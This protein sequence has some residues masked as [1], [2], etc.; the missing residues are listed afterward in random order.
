MEQYVTRPVRRRLRLP[1][2]V[3]AGLGLF[4]FV[5]L[6]LSAAG[7]Q[8]VSSQSSQ[9]SQGQQAPQLSGQVYQRPAPGPT[10]SVSG[11]AVFGDTQQPARFSS[12][13]LIP[14]ESVQTDPSRPGGFRGFGGMGGNGRTDL[15]GTFV[16]NNVAVGDYYVAG[17]SPG[18]I[19]ET[20]VLQARAADGADMQ[21]LLASLPVARVTVGTTAT[22]NL[23]LTRG[24]TIAGRIQWED[25]SPATGQQVAAMMV[26]AGTN[27][28]AAINQS[29][30][31]TLLI[32]GAFNAMSDDRGMFRLTGLAPGTYVVRASL[33]APA[34]GSGPTFFQ[35]TQ[36]LTVYAPGKLRR[37]DA[38]SIT[39]HLGEERDD[40]QWVIDLHA[41]HN[42]SGRV[43]ATS[44]P[45]PQSGSV[46]LV[47]TTD[48]TLNRSAPIGSDGSFTLSYLPPG[49]YTL[50]VSGA[51]SNPANG[52]N[53]G[54]R[55][56]QSTTTPGTTY[57]QYT[58]SLS[59]ADTD[60]SGVSINLT[61]NSSQE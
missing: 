59:V 54:R 28:V 55:G 40:L 32:G 58:G 5:W 35:R 53:A 15:D 24:G 56:G 17:Q 2:R 4:A 44:G 46:R 22:V 49:N 10:G 13:V 7:Q 36:M 12:I 50:T 16:I 37:S 45:E 19:S 3:S 20:A 30:G 48:G 60:V 23:S 34:G 31:R 41:L 42:V 47:D 39:I 61:P 11:R 52:N 57:Q 27:S 6:A 18:Y 21:A 1:E 51:S 9:S 33:Q 8:S 26:T 14:V 29:G 43:G 38:Q 25:G